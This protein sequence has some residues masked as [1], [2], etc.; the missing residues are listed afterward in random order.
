MGPPN[1][2]GH[3]P[4]KGKHLP[5]IT[6]QRAGESSPQESVPEPPLQTSK[7]HHVPLG[8]TKCFW[9]NRRVAQF[10]KAPP[11]QTIDTQH[12]DSAAEDVVPEFASSLLTAG[13]PEFMPWPRPW[14]LPPCQ[15]LSLLLPW[16]YTG[17]PTWL[18]PEAAFLLSF[19]CVVQTY[20]A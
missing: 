19:A 8:I 6:Q 11:P 5:Q 10:R 3:W 7:P 14:P 2:W 12:H 17:S 4:R 9:S 1:K 18:H 20:Q 15:P 13:S 16:P